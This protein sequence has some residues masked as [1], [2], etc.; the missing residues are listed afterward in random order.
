MGLDDDATSRLIEGAF[1]GEEACRG[2][3]LE[4]HRDRLRRMVALRLDPR[5]RGRVDPSDVIQEAFLEAVTRLPEYA[6]GA[7]MPFFLWLRLIAGQ[8]LRIV[9]RR[10]L[11]VRARDAGREVPLG[12]GAFPEASSDALAAWLA[13]GGP[14]PSEMARR[15][16]RGE[17]LRSAI[18]GLDAADREVLAL[19]H[20]EQLTNAEAA[21]VLGVSEAAAGQRHFRALKRLKN[22]LSRLP[23]GAEEILP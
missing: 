11:G 21:R 15:A 12:R 18:D 6:R 22:A 1:R 5:L 20:F 8:R 13:D 7:T 23:G 17:R 3:L 9:H 16:E 2:P 14:G 10:H 19:R 4:R